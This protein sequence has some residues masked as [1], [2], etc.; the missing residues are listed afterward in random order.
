LLCL[1]FAVPPSLAKGT[2]PLVAPGVHSFFLQSLTASFRFSIKVNIWGRY[3]LKEQHDE[4]VAAASIPHRLSFNY[5]NSI[6]EDKEP[7]NLY[8]TLIN[9]IRCFTARIME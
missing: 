8:N 1:Q 2:I 6:L 3:R 5:K 7:L 4:A 9:A